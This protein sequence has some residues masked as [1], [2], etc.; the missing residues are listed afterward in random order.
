[1][2]RKEEEGK[3]EE[4]PKLGH[5]VMVYNAETNALYFHVKVCNRVR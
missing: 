4:E 5:T 2:G 1:M 3:T